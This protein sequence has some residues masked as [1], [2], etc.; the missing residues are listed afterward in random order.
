MTKYVVATIHKWNINLYE[1]YSRKLS[2]EWHLVTDPSDLTQSLLNSLQP[3]FIFFP[4]WSWQV[5]ETLTSQYECICFHMTDVPY[6]RGGSPL[7]NLILSGH[8]DTVISALRMVEELDAG[9]VYAKAPLSLHGRAQDIYERA[10]VVTARLI[11]NIVN[12]EPLPKPQSGEVTVFKRRF[13]AESRLPEGLGPAEIYDH[14]RMLDA[15]GYPR[16]FIESGGYRFELKDASLLNDTVRA[17]VE[18]R[19]RHQSP[20]IDN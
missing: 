3:R 4:H 2:G 18:L 16:A 13:P 6:G 14:I 5:P 10:A 17:T 12:K 15:D 1:Q 7:Q 20:E 19:T 9:P 11:E 8:H